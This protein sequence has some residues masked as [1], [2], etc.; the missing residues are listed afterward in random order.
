MIKLQG[1]VI[2]TYHVDGGTNKKGETFDAS[3]KVQ[4][5]GALELPNGQIKHELVD[6]KVQ[7]ARIWEQ[8]KGRVVSISCGAMAA[9][10]SVIFYVAKGATPQ[11]VG[12]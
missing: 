5:L 8:F 4:L 11:A 9:G 10:R 1:Q 7:D 6:L 3:D 12:S 2:N